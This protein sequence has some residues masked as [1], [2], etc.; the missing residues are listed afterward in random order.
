[1]SRGRQ[2]QRLPDG[3]RLLA[4][5]SACRTT[6]CPGAAL[7]CIRSSYDAGRHHRLQRRRAGR[8]RRVRAPTGRRP[9]PRRRAPGST[10]RPGRGCRSGRRR[11]R[12][13]APLRPAA[14][15][16]RRSRARRRAEP[17]ARAPGT[18]MHQTFSRHRRRAPASANSPQSWKTWVVGAV[19]VLLPPQP[20]VTIDDY[21][22]H[23][24]GEGLRAARALGPS[25]TID[26][27]VASGLRGRGGAG[28][29]TGAKWS[30]VRGAPGGTH[31]A[32]GNGAEGEPATFKDRT[33]MRRDPLPRRR[34]TGDRR[35]RAS[36]PARRTSR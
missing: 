25:G 32:V 22:A 14:R 26:E 29:P 30:S 12:V 33:L 36:T 35:V 27:I 17:T 5:G 2:A 3:D 20:I 28:F 34:G 18:P 19:S 16:H 11:R 4:R 10:P 6:S 23:G 1:M 31:Y 24:G 7:A 8:R 15:R 9:G 21:I 13:A